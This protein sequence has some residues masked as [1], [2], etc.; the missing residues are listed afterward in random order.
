MT[1]LSTPRVFQSVAQA[2]YDRFGSIKS[3]ASDDDAKR[4]ALF[5][6]DFYFKWNKLGF[7]NGEKG[8]GL[9]ALIAIQEMITATI[10]WKIES[11]PA[12]LTNALTTL[13]ECF[14]VLI[15]GYERTKINP[16][17]IVDPR[18]REIAEKK[19][20]SREEKRSI[21]MASVITAAGAGGLWKFFKE[22]YE[23]LK[24]ENHD[25]R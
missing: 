24:G 12:T 17:K 15:S 13:S 21:A 6:D 20:K 25:I 10:L 8:L 9:G 22:T 18:E 19:L 11:T 16:E 7:V 23:S 5:S 14:Q 1:S 4:I 2:T 3:Q